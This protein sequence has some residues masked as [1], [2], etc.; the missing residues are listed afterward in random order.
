[1]CIKDYVDPTLHIEDGIIQTVCAWY[2]LALQ[3]VNIRTA[4]VIDVLY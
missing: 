1:M 2:S 4:H 3:T